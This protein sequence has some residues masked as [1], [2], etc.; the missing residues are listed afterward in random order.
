M[1]FRSVLSDA[2]VDEVE[3]IFVPLHLEN[4]AHWGLG[5]IK[6][7]EGIASFDD[8]FH[9]Q[10]LSNLV[11]ICKQLTAAVRKVSKSSTAFPASFKY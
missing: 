10:R 3:Y 5:V 9:K 4:E 7:H 8:G 11:R 6:L 2:N 1:L